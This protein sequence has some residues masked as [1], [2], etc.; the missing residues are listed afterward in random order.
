MVLLIIEGPDL[1]GKTTAIEKI[2]KH[3][4]SGFVLK[5]AYKPK[6]QRDSKIYEQYDNILDLIEN[7]EEN[8][9]TE[10]S[11]DVLIL[12]RFYPSQAVYSILRG[13]DELQE[14]RVEL[15][16]RRLINYEF[17]V[18][19]VYLDCSIDLLKCRYKE[20]GDEHISIEQLEMLKTRYDLFYEKCKLNKIKIDTMQKDW[21]EKFESFLYA[22]GVLVK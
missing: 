20:R 13:Y 11:N 10:S 18:I 2:A 15:L 7:W 22:N 6:E 9:W 1:S 14:P 3:F 4:N 21:L 8:S 17:D 16:E 12:D 5:N 19:Y